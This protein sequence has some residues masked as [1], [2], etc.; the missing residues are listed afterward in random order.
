MAGYMII[1]AAFDVI[2]E[3]VGFALFEV[4]VAN[5]TKFA[6]KHV[7]ALVI[8]QIG[9]PLVIGVV[10]PITVTTRRA[11]RYKILVF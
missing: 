8:G 6:T 3:C 10:D 1:S 11:A 7:N 4:Q 9:A 5:F 2:N